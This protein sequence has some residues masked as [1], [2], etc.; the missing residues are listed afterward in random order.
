VVLG[1]G[2]VLADESVERVRDMVGVHRVS[3]VAAA[4]PELPGVVA[5]EHADD[6]THVLTTDADAL[7]RELIH[8]GAP[9]AGLEVRPTSLEEAFLAITAPQPA[10]V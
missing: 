8:S 4:L 9:F 2:R 6:R 7:V 3:L 10:T 1:G 5:V